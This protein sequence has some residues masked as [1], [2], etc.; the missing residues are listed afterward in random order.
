VD[1]YGRV[2]RFQHDGTTTHAVNKTVPLLHDLFGER[3]VRPGL[4]PSRPPG[5]TASDFFLWGF[6]EDRVHSNNTRS[7][8][9]QKHSVEL[10]VANTDSDTLEQD[11]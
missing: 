9:K 2:W 4:R 7:L 5:P 8:E 6:L 3:M 10:T 1:E 11:A